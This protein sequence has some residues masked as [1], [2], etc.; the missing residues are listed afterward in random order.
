[1]RSRSA[2]IFALFIILAATLACGSQTRSPAIGSPLP[3]E[4]A[5]SLTPE[6]SGP[7]YNI[8]FP[9]VP[10]YQW[11]Y[12]VDSQDGNGPSKFNLTVNKIENSQATINALDMSTGVISQTIA[13]CVDGAIKNYPAMTQ[14]LLIGNAITS[15]FNM[16]YVSGVFSPTEAAF[17]NSD[18]LYNWIADYI[19]NGNIQIQEAGDVINIVVQDSPVHLTW[20]TTGSGDNA[21]ESVTVPAGTFDRALKIQREMQMD[22]SIVI[23]GISVTGKLTLRTTQWYEP[24]TGLLKSQID[25]G[26][27][28]YMGMTFP[29]DMKGTVELVEFRP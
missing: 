17:S 6:P 11:I 10:G 27:L 26:D 25:S 19:A 15:D 3:P 4:A 1:M 28:T 14:K 5:P 8:L 2:L 12:Q 7:C 24:F 20:Q 21:F 29:I 9:F 16:E 22:G 13:E 18:W 23:Q